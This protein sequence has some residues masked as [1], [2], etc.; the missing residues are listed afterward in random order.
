MKVGPSCDQFG[1]FHKQRVKT[2]G[3]QTSGQTTPGDMAMTDEEIELR[4]L[5]IELENNFKPIFEKHGRQ[6]VSLGELRA[7]LE[8][9]GLLEHIGRSRM[10]QLLVLA[11]RDRDK[12]ITYREFYRMM[13]HEL[14]AEERRPFKRVMRA[15]IADLVP[16]RMREDFLANYNCCPPP[17]FIPVISAI[18]I[19]IFI[20]YVFELKEDGIET[21]ATSGVPIKSPL[22][23]NP[24]RR[25]EAWR[26][27]SYMFIHQGYMHIIINMV[28]QLVFGLSLEMVHKF[29]RV[30]LVYVLG[31]I[32]GCLIHSVTDMQVSLVGASGG[33]YAILGAH[34]AAIVINWREMNYRCLDPQEDNVCCGFCRFMLSAPVRLAI[35]LFLVVSDTAA[36]VHRRIK[37]PQQFKVGVSAHIGGFVAGIFMGVLILR[38]IKRHSWERTLGW[39]MLA[40]YL[41]FVAF[42]VLFNV[43]YPGYPD[44]DWDRLEP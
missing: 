42:C 21:R 44:T 26:F 9:E 37:E 18:E 25:Y 38:N 33:V 39:T 17:I 7:E 12:K 27:A 14:T 22:V 16:R 35:I 24:R 13:T 15:A 5:H 43:F 31:A 11:D 8:E 19:G 2:L 34:V 30:G 32:A 20:C 29:W 1:F 23:Y 36:A 3:N 40:L 10:D 4:Q 28:F 6:G 41:A